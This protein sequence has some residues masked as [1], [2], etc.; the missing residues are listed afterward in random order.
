MESTILGN[1]TNDHQKAFMELLGMAALHLAYVPYTS[2]GISAGGLSVHD[3]IPA[4]LGSVSPA[5]PAV[6]KI[7]KNLVPYI[8]GMLVTA[9][10][11]I[12]ACD[13]RAN[14]LAE[15]H[16]NAVLKYLNLVLERISPC[17]SSVSLWS[18]ML[19]RRRTAVVLL[20]ERRQTKRPPGKGGGGAE[21]VAS[22]PC[23]EYYGL[24]NHCNPI[25]R[26][27]KTDRRT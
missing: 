14:G 3:A 5:L 21:Q 16:A 4:A 22:R 11:A 18:G 8:A 25:S 1:R 24:I 2:D 20:Q 17:F 10:Y 27:K 15:A 13:R 6:P 26:P 19:Q 23:M 9:P 7:S 12:G